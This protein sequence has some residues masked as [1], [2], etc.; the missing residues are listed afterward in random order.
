MS[1][2]AANQFLQRLEKESPLRGQ[3]Y[4]S[5]PKTF[6][7]LVTFAHGKGFVLEADELKA[8]LDSYKSQLKGGGNIDA[9]KQLV[10]G[11]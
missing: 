10:S 6:D 1:M 4:I 3:L 2:E 8:A 9:L 11:Q 5:S 7:E